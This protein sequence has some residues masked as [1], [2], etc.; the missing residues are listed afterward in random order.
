MIEPLHGSD[1]LQ[2]EALVLAGGESRRM[3]GHDKA[4]IMYRALPL[5]EHVVARLMAQSLPAS[6]I[7]V[8]A[9]RNAARYAERGVST[10]ADLRFESMGPLA[11]IEAAFTEISADYL[12]VVPCDT[13]AL[14]ANLAERLA[15]AMLET[16]SRAAYAHTRQGPQ[17]VCCLLHRSLAATVTDWLDKGQRQVL[18]W[19]ESVEALVVDF[20]DDAGFANINTPECLAQLEAAQTAPPSAVPSASMAASPLTHFDAAGRAHMV[21]VSAKAETHRSATAAGAISMLPA[22]FALIRD[23]GSQKGDVLGVARLAGIMA[24]KRCGDLI[25]LCHPIP[26]TRVVVDFSLDEAS[27]SVQC[28][29][30]AE[31]VGR[32]GVE[33][34]ALSAVSVALLTI[35]DMCKAVDRAMQMDAVR[36]LEKVGGKSGHWRRE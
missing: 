5:F 30:T 31:T 32:T 33:M 8:S 18:R 36:L 17:P 35:Y 12:L 29:A 15:S 9:N 10:L 7:H 6:R 16:G 24:A 1:S 13:P 27:A 23:G 14:P 11:G 34:E 26:L 28:T 3:G 25:P 2:Y 20:H 22:T 21:D 19:L 4:L